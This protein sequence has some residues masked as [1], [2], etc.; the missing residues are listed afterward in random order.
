MHRKS[1]VFIFLITALLS[2]KLLELSKVKKDFIYVV[3]KIKN[4]EVLERNIGEYTLSPFS[5][6]QL[7]AHENREEDGMSVE[8]E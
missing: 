8:L 4:F 2:F 7:R 6:T 1:L 5:N 3:P